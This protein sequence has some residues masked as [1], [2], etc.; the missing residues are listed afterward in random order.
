[1]LK[2]LELFGFKSFADRTRFEFAPGITC[3]VGPNGSG[4]SNVVDSIKWILGDQS[5]K[6]MRGKEMTD[7]IFNGASGRK[8]SGFAEAMLSF[9]N[10]SGF[11]PI[12]GDEIQVGRR[13]YRSGESEYL[14]NKSPARLKDV[15]DLLMGSGAGS[16]AYSIIEQGRVDQ[17]LQSSNV[18]RRAVFEEA[19]GISRFKSRKV[20][21]QRR[22]E[23]VAQNLVRLTDIVEE[24]H[25]RLNTIRQQAKKATRFRKYSAELRE[26]RVGLAADDYRQL[27]G[28]L[29]K[30]GNGRADW[31]AEIEKLNLQYSE[32]EQQQAAVE[33]QVSEIE[34]RLGEA[35]KRAAEHR[36][37]I[38]GAQATVEHQTTRRGELESELQRLKQQQA[39]LVGRAREVIHELQET[40]T[41]LLEFESNSAKRRAALAQMEAAIAQSG[42]ELTA[43]LQKLEEDREHLLELKQQ[44]AVLTGRLA[45]LESQVNESEEALKNAEKVATKWERELTQADEDLANGESAVRQAEHKL[46]QAASEIDAQ[47]EQLQQLQEKQADLQH[48]VSQMREDR[49]GHDARR[50]VLEDLESRQEGIGVGVREILQR[51]R[52]NDMPPWNA[53]RGSVADL[54]QVDLEHAGLIEVALGGRTQL[55]VLDDTSPLLDYL[56][57]KTSHISGRVG[58]LAIGDPSKKLNPSDEPT[59]ND[60]SGLS[61]VVARADS[62]VNTAPTATGLAERLLAD[63]WVVESLADALRISAEQG[64]DC[65]FVTLQ[66]ELLESDGTVYAGTLQGE[67]SLV[68]RKSE[69]RRLKNDLLKLDRRIESTESELKTIQSQATTAA[70]RLSEIQSRQEQDAQSLAEL[71]S[72]ALNQRMLSERLQR[73]REETQETIESHR[74]ELKRFGGERDN[75]NRQL[76]ELSEKLQQL[77]T[78][79]TRGQQEADE[80]E[81]ELSERRE[82]LSF[83]RME[84]AKQD[85]RLENLQN[86]R[87]RLGEERHQRDAHREEAERRYLFTQEKH[88]KISLQW[89]NTRALLAEL[90]LKEESSAAEVMVHSRAREQIRETRSRLSTEELKLRRDLRELE[91]RA[92]AQEMRERDI[93]NQIANLDERLQ[94]EYGVSLAQSAE[95]GASA[96]KL[97]L[98]QRRREAESED[99]DSNSEAN[100]DLE[101][102]LEDS[103]ESDPLAPQEIDSEEVAEDLATEDR[104]LQRSE[105]PDSEFDHPPEL[106]EEI[107]TEIEQRI[108]ALRRKLK[109]IGHVST[110]SLQELEEL[111]IRYDRLNGQLQDLTE[112]KSSLED[113]VRRI[114]SESRRLFLETYE[115]IRKH[116]QELFRKLFGGGD[117]DIILEDAEDILECGIDIVA[118][119]PGKEL[120]SISLLSGGE[121]TL[122]AVALLMALFKSRPGPFC[123]L[124]E[125]DAALDEANTERYVGVIEEFQDTTQFIVITHAKRTMMVADV[126]YGVT[127]QESGISKRMSV[128]FEDVSPDGHFKIPTNNPDA[129]D[130]QSSDAA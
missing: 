118:R 78:A 91:E 20:D 14:I 12:E 37:A 24:L 75:V 68:S 106:I 39:T 57:N 47:R 16:A 84:L 11:L 119:P 88:E 100:Q 87:T 92:H 116:F 98:E 40:E 51:A 8:P 89:L 83:E 61:G 54:L 114:N 103:T 48:A 23:R 122:T 1:M 97:Y 59:L 125:V 53:I 104:E 80:L 82:Q 76:E 99:A 74:Q 77:T 113:I 123:I 69:L 13:L 85:E 127:M 4:K 45:S 35:Q 49:S 112:A 126:L 95:E 105:H 81:R 21:A 110:E 121:K 7:V 63:T 94:E 17:L 102:D 26:L 96:I 50:Q 29:Q 38:A 64:R 128:R 15:R 3:V 52:E 117:G 67:T 34:D 60:L 124:D 6:S 27:T 108:A 129:T 55:I 62:Y 2:S 58:F 30:T 70:D 93:R 28:E 79:I 101:N 42:G 107:H 130:K 115:E 90:S 18:N 71:K 43:N 66:G 22:L 109:S 41:H 46:Q 9:D 65:R 86:A 25:S 36:E 33:A 32:I 111:E 72:T 31:Q 44:D 56:Q 73:N 10:S 19:A 5:A 120:R